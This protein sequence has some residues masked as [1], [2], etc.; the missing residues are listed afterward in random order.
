MRL[1]TVFVHDTV[2]VI[3]EAV[4]VDTVVLRADTVRLQKDRWRVRII[5]V[6]DS[7]QVDGGCDPDTVRKVVKL[8]CPPMVQPTLTVK[9]QLPWWKVALMYLGGAF[10][11][12]V[13]FRLATTSRA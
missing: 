13:L 2:T 9:A 1:D 12:V 8:P 4:R 7:M 6:G 10:I 3:T 5:Q 11:L